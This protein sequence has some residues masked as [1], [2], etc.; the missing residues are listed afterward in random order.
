MPTLPAL[1]TDADLRRQIQFS[2]ADGRIWLAG[3]RMVLMHAASLGILRRELMHTLGPAAT[4]R[5]LLRVGH[6]SGER[7][8]ALARQLRPG[9]DAFAMFSVGPQLHMLQ[10]AVQVTPEKLELDAATGHF[11]GI[12]AWQQ[13]W[14]VEV[15]VRDFG[16][17]SAPVCWML[18]GY[19]SGYTSA[20][21][22]RTVLYKEVQCAAGGHAHCR[23]EGRPVQDWPDGAQ[24]AADYAPD[25]LPDGGA[26][27]DGPRALPAWPAPMPAEDRPEPPADAL[28]PLIGRS[29]GFT[30]ATRLLRKAAGTQVTVLLT[31]ET[32]VGK[33]RFAR[34]LHALSPRAAKPFV[35]VNCAALPG[36][37][38]E[39]ELFGTEKG[40]YTGADAAR[41]GRFERA[42]GGTL[43]LD[44]L[45]ELPLSAQ[46][47]LLRVL[48]DGQVER[49]G[50]T[51]PR[52]V[53]VRLVAATHV[54][55]QD[56]V[57]AGR[58]RQDLYYRLNVYPIRIPPLRERQDD[59][60]PF[61]R[62]LLQRFAALHD[63]HIG[64]LTDR[65]LHALRQYAWPGNVRE[66]ENLIERG[67][68]LADPGQPVDAA[69]LFP[70]SA[71]AAAPAHTLQASGRL[72]EARAPACDAALI[73]RL[74]GERLDLQA[75]E[76]HL[77]EAAVERSHGNLAAAARLLGLTRPQLS[78]RLNKVRD[79]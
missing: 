56:A 25:A 62:H 22:G 52:Q 9:A 64:G 74:L 43:F 46:A 55:L 57:R 27:Q 73:D 5:L 37:L 33:E 12:F 63:K 79:I 76:T 8:A 68:I 10:G 30:A 19:A 36:S 49:L 20:F 6:A 32:G 54:D 44:E 40:A 31:G 60:E 3:Q 39:S 11:H 45:G 14:E 16:P 7:D 4:R 24:L 78:Y 42:H 28:G 50:A 1:P 41:A 58:F 71:P 23:I 59:I 35:A 17:Q 21:M 70:D 34:A 61:A 65:A 67:V 53:D 51:Q 18:L 13:S 26:P 15:H 47:K 48:Q 75:L 29:A 77:I 38:V 69:H 72:G 2:A 66:M